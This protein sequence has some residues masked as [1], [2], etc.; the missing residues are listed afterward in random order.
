M[1]CLGAMNTAV[2][3]DL[4]PPSIF[5]FALVGIFFITMISCK[6]FLIESIFTFDLIGAATFRKTRH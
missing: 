2:H 6:I 1:N 3:L 5:T 4:L